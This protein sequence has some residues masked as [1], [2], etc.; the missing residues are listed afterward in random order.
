M[1]LELY[2]RCYPLY[3]SCHHLWSEQIEVEGMDIS[4][5]EGMNM[6]DE[7]DHPTNHQLGRKI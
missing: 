5:V 4:E 3:P 2:G 1:K 7:Q 6:V